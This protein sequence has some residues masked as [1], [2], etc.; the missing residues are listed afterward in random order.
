MIDADDDITPVEAARGFVEG[1]RGQN[2]T[3]AFNLL[4][5][6]AQFD[7]AFDR[8]MYLDVIADCHLLPQLP[9]SVKA[10][11][12]CGHVERGRAVYFAFEDAQSGQVHVAALAKPSGS[13]LQTAFLTLSARDA[14]KE[15]RVMTQIAR[16][17]HGAAALVAA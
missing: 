4:F 11:L 10:G 12:A 13:P 8:A 3:Q 16:R 2:C 6:S 1:L 5:N 14:R 15:G 7:T 9:E 17:I